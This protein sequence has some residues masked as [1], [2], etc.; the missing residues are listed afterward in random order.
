MA[1]KVIERAFDKEASVFGKWRQDTAS[2]LNSAFAEDIKLWKGYRFIKSDDD[3]ADTEAVLKK[4]FLPL[5]N[6]FIHLGATSSWPNI[7][8]LDF[9]DFATKAK[10]LDSTVNI[11]TIDRAFIAANLKVESAT[12]PS[13]GLKRFEYLEILVRLGNIKFLETRIVKTYA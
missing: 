4:Y 7:G 10:F 12:A 5:K 13:N 8:S 2:S 9:C 3:K 6:I 1:N 11:S